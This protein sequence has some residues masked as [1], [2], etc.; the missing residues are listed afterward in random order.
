M[1]LVN[2]FIANKSELGFGDMEQY[3]NTQITKR[4]YFSLEEGYGFICITNHENFIL[5]TTIRLEK[6]KGIWVLPPF[7]LP[8]QLTVFPFEN[9][10]CKFLVD[11][12]GYH[13]HIK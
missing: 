3:T 2:D 11:P 7:N 10:I 12:E 4:R 9:V 5:E 1:N 6:L 8:L 13:Y